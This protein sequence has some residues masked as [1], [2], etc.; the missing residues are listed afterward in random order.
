MSRI[1]ENLF[2]G[3]L[4]AAQDWDFICKNNI[5]YILNATKDPG[6]YVVTGIPNYYESNP[7][8]TCVGMSSPCSHSCLGQQVFAMVFAG[9]NDA[10]SM[11]IL[12]L[13]SNPNC[14]NVLNLSRKE[15]NMVRKSWKL[16]V[17]FSNSVTI[18]SFYRFR[19]SALCGR[20]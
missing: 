3:G 7:N 12:G 17:D 10:P 19:V 11:M 6:S 16:L 8:V 2:V 13:K 5:K 9:I 18:I 14:L 15:E 4:E 1:L 20:C